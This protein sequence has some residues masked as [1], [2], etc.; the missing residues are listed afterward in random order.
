MQCSNTK[1]RVVNE[2]AEP[3]RPDG[4]YECYECRARRG[5]VVEVAAKPLVEPPTPPTNRRFSKGHFVRVAVAA[6]GTMTT[7]TNV[8]IDVWKMSGL[9]PQGQWFD[10]IM[11]VEKNGNLVVGDVDVGPA[12]AA[13]NVRVHDARHYAAVAHEHRGNIVVRQYKIGDPIALQIAFSFEL[14]LSFY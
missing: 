10:Q 12:F 3:N 14:Y 6:D 9:D 13:T 4:T 11:F 5:A 8:D 2:F 7:S 1:C